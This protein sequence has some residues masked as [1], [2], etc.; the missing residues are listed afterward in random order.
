VITPGN[1]TFICLSSA[2]SHL[3]VA[4]DEQIWRRRLTRAFWILAVVSGALHAWDGRHSM[5]TDGVSYLDLGDAFWDGDRTALIN[6]VWSPLYP[7]V[8]GFILQVMR[9][10][11]YWEF[12]VVHLVNFGIYLSALC[13]FHFFLTGWMRF[14][15]VSTRGPHGLPAWGWIG[16]GYSLFLWSSLYLITIRWV[17]PDLAVAAFFY[18]ACGILVRLAAGYGSWMASSVLGVILALGY[19]TKA[20][21]FPLA[22]IFLAAAAHYLR[23]RHLGGRIA[24]AGVIAFASV[25][26]PW[27]AIY[28][29][30]KG[31]LT[32]SDVGRLNYAWH[33]NGT[34]GHVHWRGQPPGSGLPTHP[35]RRILDR[36]EIYEFAG[37]VAGTFPVW[38]DPAYWNEGITVHFDLPEQLAVLRTNGGLIA[39]Q[40]LGFRPVALA[41]VILLILSRPRLGL[42]AATERWIVALPALVGLAAYALV[43]VEPR[44]VGSFLVIVWFALISMVAVDWQGARHSLRTTVATVTLVAAIVLGSSLFVWDTYDDGRDA[45]RTARGVAH[46]NHEHWDV[47]SELGQLGLVAGDHVG[48]VGDRMAW[49]RLAR[50]RI[51]A[52]LPLRDADRF[53]HADR[54]A[55]LQAV[56]AFARSGAKAIVTRTPSPIAD[57]GWRRIR[58]TDY[59]VRLL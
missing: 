57:P 17:T 21:L 31:R 25:A 5:N 43:H 14:Q 48:V 2:C 1:S 37:P 35:T 20:I 52:H 50:L 33:V 41:A 54:A 28:S 47:A 10:T 13:S 59:Y 16:I 24:I 8:V 39:G 26:G 23:Q 58:N 45:L 32:F 22:F 53:F 3:A 12:S 4:L 49:A 18:L 15:N 55:Q 42:R 34:T 6:G 29:I 40:L 51:V 7:F 38:S 30:T 56:H 11:P 27:V 19:L 46:E 44:L 9:P 36:P